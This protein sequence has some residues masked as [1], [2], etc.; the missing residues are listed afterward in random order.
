MSKNIVVAEIG[1]FNKKMKKKFKISA[2][3][4]SLWGHSLE[5]TIAFI[6]ECGFDGIEI[7]V[8]EP[9]LSLNFLLKQKKEIL[10]CLRGSGLEVVSFTTITSFTQAEAAPDSVSTVK[11]LTDLCADFGTS[12]VKISPGPPA[13]GKA[14]E[15]IWDALKSKMDEVVSYAGERGVKLAMETHLNMLTDTIDGTRHFLD[16]FTSPAV[17]LTLDFCNVMVGKDD[18]EQAVREFAGR[19]FLCHVKDGILH[20][21]GTPEWLPLGEGSLDYPGIVQSLSQSAYSGYL[22]LECL[23]K[24]NRY[25]QNR[26]REMGGEKKALKHDKDM[27][28]RYLKK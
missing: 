7:I 10:S 14:S 6:A 2:A 5:E 27:L 23:V 18:P 20:E 25:N 3:T 9:W 4:Q 26:L 11:K 17:G 1:S 16:L 13:S 22:S 15:E 24:D 19:T 12:I 21:N 28:L 8:L